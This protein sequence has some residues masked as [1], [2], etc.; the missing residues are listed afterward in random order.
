MGYQEIEDPQARALLDEA[1]LQGVGGGGG[2]L[3]LGFRVQD[4]GFQV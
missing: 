3:G 4:L 2:A 1:E